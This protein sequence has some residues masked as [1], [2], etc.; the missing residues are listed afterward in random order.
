M[1]LASK[2][3]VA[4][5]T[6]TLFFCSTRNNL[7]NGIPVLTVERFHRLFATLASSCL[8]QAGVQ[9]PVASLCTNGYPVNARVQAGRAEPSAVPCH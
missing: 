5:S 4:P 7:G 2:T 8:L 9:M 6:R 1:I 3:Y